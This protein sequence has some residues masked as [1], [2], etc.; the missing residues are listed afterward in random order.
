[1]SFV[2]S[3]SCLPIALSVQVEVKT[4]PDTPDSSN[5][6]R[7]ADF[8]H[9]FILGFEVQVG[10]SLCCDLH[11]VLVALIAPVRISW[12]SAVLTLP[13]TPLIV[14]LPSAV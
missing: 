10:L 12:R 9:A 8:I 3:C 5:L 4:T 1:M 11:A 13:C 2:A 7:A 14:P 6:Q